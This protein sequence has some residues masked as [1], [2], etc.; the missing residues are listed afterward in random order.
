MKKSKIVIA[1]GLLVSAFH[2]FSAEKIVHTHVTFPA[3]KNA[4]GARI[5]IHQLQKYFQN[6]HLEFAMVDTLY[7]DNLTMSMNS[8]YQ[9][10]VMDPHTKERLGYIRFRFA[11][12][13]FGISCYLPQNEAAICERLAIKP[14]QF[15]ELP[16]DKV[17]QVLSLAVNQ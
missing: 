8:S 1:L 7:Q 15:L 5:E 11:P 17:V 4:Q 12:G 14:L 6:R 16:Q 3:N 9:V 10:W 13:K 2:A